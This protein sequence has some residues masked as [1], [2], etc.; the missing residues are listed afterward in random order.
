MVL[1]HAVCTWY[2]SKSVEW[3]LVE[4]PQGD[5]SVL[6]I[7][8]SWISVKLGSRGPEYDEVW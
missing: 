6:D 5:Y 7:C 3:L 2:L 4:A 8:S 1:F